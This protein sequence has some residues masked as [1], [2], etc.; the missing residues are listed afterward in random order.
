MKRADIRPDPVRKFKM[1]GNPYVLFLPFLVAYILIVVL[2]Q[3]NSFWGDEIRYYGLAQRLLHGYFS[4][5]A[6]N[7]DCPAGPGYPIF[8]APFLA[9]HLPLLWIRLL[10]PILY[11]LS[12]VL[13]FKTLRQFVPLKLALIVSLF[14]AIY[15]NAFEFMPLLLTETLAIFLI[16]LVLFSLSKAFAANSSDKHVVLAGFVLGYLALTK[17]VFGYVLL[18]ML[19]GNLGL[20]MLAKRKSPYKRAVIVIAIAFFTTAPYLAYTYHLTGRI[21]YW[22]SGS[23]SNLYWMSSPLQNEYGNWFAD[24]QPG[25]GSTEK[26]PEKLYSGGELSLKNRGTNG[27]PGLLDSLEVNH[28]EDFDEINKYTGIER[29]DAFQRIAVKNIKA[30]PGKYVMNCFS[31]LG[32]VLFNYP[33]SYTLQKPGTLLRLPLNGIIVVVMLLSLVPAV[34]NWKKIPFVIRLLF[35]FTLIYL[36]GSILESAEFRMFSIVV[37]IILLWIA[38]IVHK[39]VQI[40]L[41]FDKNRNTL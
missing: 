29:D 11:Y 39:S 18:A 14:W 17:V 36:G 26:T 23:S 3:S 24:L 40:S 16:C 27:M 6:P 12:V 15:F 33:Y 5:P 7:I 4:P 20:W 19:I 34:T 35:F 10:N 28:K 25:S 37:P 31:N 21:F 41:V 13:L 8:I 1:P 38:Y 2:L 9:G 32:R 30:H 22:S